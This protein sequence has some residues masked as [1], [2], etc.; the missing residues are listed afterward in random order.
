MKKAIVLLAIVTVGM[1]GCADNGPAHAENV[2]EQIQ[3]MKPE[4]R[5]ELIKSN[6]GMSIQMKDKAID[7]LPVSEEQKQAWKDE[8]RQGEAQEQLSR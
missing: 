3:K 5:F 2:T 4:D 6:T 8:L 1:V 7:G